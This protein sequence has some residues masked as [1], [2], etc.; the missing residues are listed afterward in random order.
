[1]TSSDSKV[2]D[3]VREVDGEAIGIVVYIMKDADVVVVN[4]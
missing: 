1:M 2:G 3:Y 4:P